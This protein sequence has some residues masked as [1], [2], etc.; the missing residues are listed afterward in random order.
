MILPIYVYGSSILRKVAKDIDKEYEGL[1]QLISDMF[2]TM[3]KTEGV[4]LAAPQIGR[5]IR[6]FVIDASPFA[7]DEPSLEGFK[8]VFINAK[9]VEKSGEEWIFNEGCLS[10][11]G[12]REDVKRVENIKIQYYDENFEYHEEVFSGLASR[13]IQHEYDHLEGM[14]FTDKVSAIRKKLLKNRLNGITKGKFD[15][16][17]A[18]NLA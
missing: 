9:I 4:G 7:E 11:P 18:V 5:S 15:A 6:I 2:D 1:G 13:V 14:V 3:Y 8:K 10:I 16:K 17:Y 12:V